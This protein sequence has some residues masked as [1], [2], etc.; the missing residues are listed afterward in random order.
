MQRQIV[1]HHGHVGI[2]PV[3]RRRFPPED[4]AGGAQPRDQPLRRGLFIARGAVD[5]ARTI[6]ARNG[7]QLQRSM[8]G[9][10]ID[11]IVFDRVAR[12]FHHDMLQPMHGPKHVQLHVGGQRSADAVGIDQMRVE[13]FRLEEYLMA[14]PIGEAMDLVLDGRAIARPA[15][16]DRAGEKRRAMQIRADDVVTALVGARDRAEKLRITPPSRQGGHGPA[17]GVGRLLGKARPSDAAPV[18]PRRRAGL[19]ARHG[20]CR[21]PHL[22][23]KPLRR[24]LADPAADDAL[25]APEERSAKKGSRAQHHRMRADPGAVGQQQPHHPSLFEDQLGRFAGHHFETGLRGDGGLDCRLEQLA[26]G[27]DA[28]APHRAALRPVEH[29]IMDRRG[30]GRAADKPV[31]RIH[32]AHEMPLA[33][34]A[35]RGIATHGPDRGRVEAHQG[36]A[37]AHSCGRRRRLAAGMAAADHH[38]IEAPHDCGR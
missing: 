13:P 15:R 6:Q 37:R 4:G 11:V 32:F 25:L 29:A 12:N 9:A 1:D 26:I 28:R 27:L 33:Q 17:L 34:P 10:R 35:D 3:Q 20:Q 8:Q 23:R 21:I 2:G 38:D 18:Q 14:V 30:I 5:L 31:E 24:S 16:I 36:G 7:P 22:R 19:E